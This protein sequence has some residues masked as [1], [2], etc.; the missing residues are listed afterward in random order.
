MCGREPRSPAEGQRGLSGHLLVSLLRA[1]ATGNGHGR[2]IASGF[3][4]QCHHEEHVYESMDWG[5]SSLNP[6]RKR[7]RA[8]LR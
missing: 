4:N 1:K 8:Y 7:K 6:N 3:V 5:D 2:Q